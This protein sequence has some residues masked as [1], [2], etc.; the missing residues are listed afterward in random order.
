MEKSLR[1]IG[2]KL[3]IL[4]VTVLLLSLFSFLNFKPPGFFIIVS[5]VLEL[6]GIVIGLIIMVYGTLRKD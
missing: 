3:Q 4:G 6:I 5:W 1:L 2:I